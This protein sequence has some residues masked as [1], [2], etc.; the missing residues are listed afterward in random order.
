MADFEGYVRPV[1]PLLEPVT[2]A[3]ERQ[4]HR[5]GQNIRHCLSHRLPKCR[6]VVDIIMSGAADGPEGDEIG[7]GAPQKLGPRGP[8]N[9]VVFTGDECDRGLDCFLVPQPDPYDVATRGQRAARGN[10]LTRL[11]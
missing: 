6:H 8:D 9:S 5:Q 1:T 10:G 4:S 2:G 7:N 3:R 11:R